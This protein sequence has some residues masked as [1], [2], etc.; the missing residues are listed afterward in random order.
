MRYGYD[1]R[2]DPLGVVYDAE[3][4]ARAKREQMREKNRFE[5]D[6]RGNGEIRL[7]DYYTRNYFQ[8]HDLDE[9]KLI[10]QLLVEQHKIIE[11]SKRYEDG[12]WVRF[13]RLEKENEQLTEENK[14]LHYKII[15]L[16][17]KLGISE[18]VI[19]V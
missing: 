1:Y 4:E 12:L 3:L 7:V 9:A 13:T 10:Y 6:V 5:V 2:L 11:Q 14:Q 16:Q 15:E 17:D 8:M 18:K 19:D